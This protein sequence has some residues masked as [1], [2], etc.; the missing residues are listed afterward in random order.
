MF[1]KKIYVQ[2]IEDGSEENLNA[3]KDV[4]G[5][6]D[7]KIAIYELVKTAKKKTKVILED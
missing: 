2:K 6:D 1:P 7:G 3:Y 5:T 4:R